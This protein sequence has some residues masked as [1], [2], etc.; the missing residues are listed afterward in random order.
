MSQCV[1]HASLT[2]DSAVLKLAGEECGDY[3]SIC[4]YSQLH[5][6]NAVFDQ[7]YNC[8]YFGNYNNAKDITGT[9][10]PREHLELAFGP[11]DHD[12]SEYPSL[13]GMSRKFLSQLQEWK[14]T[15]VN[16]HIVDRYGAEICNKTNV[17]DKDDTTPFGCYVFESLLAFETRESGNIFWDKDG[18]GYGV[19]SSTTIERDAFDPEKI[20]MK[21]VASFICLD[22]ID[23]INDD[24]LTT[25]NQPLTCQ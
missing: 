10:I 19:Y 12:Q 15:G 18:N 21:C 11:D 14:K 2:N 3:V 24:Y 20:K 1:V 7:V 22:G 9:A 4:D 13:I 16:Q 8:G 5:S 23:D 25:I 6:S 17:I